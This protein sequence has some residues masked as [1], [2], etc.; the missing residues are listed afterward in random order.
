MAE[1]LA[2]LAEAKRQLNGLLPQQAEMAEIL[3][4]LAEAKRQLKGLLPLFAH[5]QTLLPGSNPVLIAAI[6][7]M[8]ELLAKYKALLPQ[9]APPGPSPVLIG[10]YSL[11]RS[12]ARKHSDQT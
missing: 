1:I 11:A 2:E 10:Y 5:V 12:P 8:N 4:E 6:A 9:Q 7:E 3:A